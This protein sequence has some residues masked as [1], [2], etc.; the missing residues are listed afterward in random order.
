[1]RSFIAIARSR[2]TMASRWVVAVAAGAML[3]P[4]TAGA[5]SLPTVSTGAAHEV[6][7]GSAVL[8][9]TVNPNGRDTSYY[10]QYG[11]TRAYGGQT[12]IA[13]A[14]AA[15]AAAATSS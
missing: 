2:C 4:A 5:A 13:D 12:A 1:M 7:Y 10:F 8:T 3:L 11:L 9:G 14:R 15:L 6:S